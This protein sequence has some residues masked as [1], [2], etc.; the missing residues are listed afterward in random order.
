MNKS[1]FQPSPP[2]SLPTL[3]GKIGDWL[4]YVTLMP[5]IQVAQRVRLPEEIDAYNEETKLG[6]WIQ[7]ELDE[8]RTRQIVNYLNEQPQRFFNSLILGIYG[9][10]PAWQELDV[11]TVSQSNANLTEETLDYLGRTFGILTLSGEERIFAIDGQHRAMGIRKTVE[12]GEDLNEEEVPIIF[13][14]HGTQDI[15]KVRTR[16]LFSTLNRYAKPVNKTEQIALSEDDNS[17]ILARMVVE[18]YSRFFGKILW[19]K[20]RVIS[21]NNTTEFSNIW[22]LYDGIQTLLTNKTVFGINVNGFNT[23]RFSNQRISDSELEKQY[24]ILIDLFEKLINE[25]PSLNIFFE[26][27][28]VNRQERSAS[29]LF[30]PIGQNILFAVLKV[31]RERNMENEA[32]QFFIRD[33]FNLA[34]SI[35]EQIFW[36]S[37]TGT[38]STEKAKQRYAFLLILEA[39]GIQVNRTAKDL[40]VYN[41]FN[42]SPSQLLN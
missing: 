29:L 3:R 12:E 32:F 7:R 37:E 31:A 41:N 36:D 39:I 40:E 34:N 42:I 25:I 1:H 5:F 30:R 9:G 33:N 23:F 4:Y 22:V 6:D 18:K 16:R 17:A 38:L 19:N 35:W 20:T 28:Y 8:N 15:G 13:V 27:G 21:P 11:S 10:K 2:L 24:G 14:A 26:T